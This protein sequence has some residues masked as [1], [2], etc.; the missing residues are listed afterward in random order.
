MALA[1]A[2]EHWLHHSSIVR[3]AHSQPGQHREN[4]RQKLF[5]SYGTRIA[6]LLKFFVKLLLYTTGHSQGNGPRFFGGM[7]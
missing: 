3:P 7:P 4:A 1:Y 5:R 6:R 2:K